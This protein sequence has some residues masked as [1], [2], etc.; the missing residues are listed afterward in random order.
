[1]PIIFDIDPPI[2]SV[3]RYTHSDCISE[4]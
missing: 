2:L 3:S 1:L 4:S